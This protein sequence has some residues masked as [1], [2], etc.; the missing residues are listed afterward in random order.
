LNTGD[1]DKDG[2][3]MNRAG[4][5]SGLRGLLLGLYR[6]LVQEINLLRIKSYSPRQRGAESAA[7]VDRLQG[8]ITVM[9]PPGDADLSVIIHANKVSIQTRL[10][11]P[12]YSDTPVMSARPNALSQSL[13]ERHTTAILR[14]TTGNKLINSIWDHLHSSIRS[15][16]A[17]DAEA[18]RLHADIMDNALR[19]AANY[20]SEDEYRELVA[21]LDKE[22]TGLTR[23]SI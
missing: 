1:H 23:V 12:T 13:N 4:E 17:G 5:S 10:E 3:I 6:Q 21:S 7:L 14:N 2:V 9:P 15:A 19:E 16:K 20:V 18:A 22:L 11:P 8:Y